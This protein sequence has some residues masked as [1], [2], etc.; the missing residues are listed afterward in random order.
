MLP[1]IHYTKNIVIKNVFSFETIDEQGIRPMARYLTLLE[2][3]I[4]LSLSAF[5]Q[6][7]S[8]LPPYPQDTKILWNNCFGTFNWE[9]GTKYVGY[10][11]DS[12]KHGNQLNLNQPIK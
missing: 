11:K 9:D 7:Q 10:R 2:L 8:K 5:A 6:A 12:N 4:G 3:L 1:V